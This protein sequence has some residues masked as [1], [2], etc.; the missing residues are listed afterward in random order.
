[1]DLTELDRGEKINEMREEEIDAI[2]SFIQKLNFQKDNFNILNDE[3]PDSLT[4]LAESLEGIKERIKI[5]KLEKGSLLKTSI[6]KVDKLLKTYI[7]NR[8]ER[9]LNMK[10]GFKIISPSDMG[11]HNIIKNTHGLNFIDFEYAGV[12]SAVASSGFIS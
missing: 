2:T 1:M 7:D 11:L 8:T 4:T 12:D 9:I 5:I 3:A 6:E 10:Y